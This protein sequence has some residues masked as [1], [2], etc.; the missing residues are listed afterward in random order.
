MC[1]HLPQKGG[2]SFFSLYGRWADNKGRIFHESEGAKGKGL[3]VD[4]EWSLAYEHRKSKRT[5]VIVCCC[6]ELMGVIEMGQL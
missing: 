5:V 3:V 2:A 4:T 1:L 6:M